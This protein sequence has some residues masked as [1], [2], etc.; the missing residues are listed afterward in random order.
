MLVH[1]VE[2][3]VRQIFESDAEYADC[4]LLE[5][6]WKKPRLMVFFDAD[7]GV[8][9]QKC[10]KLSRLIESVLEE[11]TGPKDSYVLEVSSGGLD[12]P[13]KFHRQYIK[14]IDRFLSI[15]L[16]DGRE[17]VGKLLHVTDE[18][19]SLEL[20]PLKPHP[21]KEKT[22]IQLFFKDIKSS[23]VQISI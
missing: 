22:I 19:I 15:H 23:T 7:S 16:V 18:A 20:K 4:F 1:Q 9:L 5:V 2:E 14:N 11:S 8:T 21:K 6:S 17:I 13:L 12:R 10:Q 3:I